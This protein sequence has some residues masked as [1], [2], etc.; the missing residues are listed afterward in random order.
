[1]LLSS[2]TKSIELQTNNAVSTDWYTAYVDI[3]PTTFVPG[4]NAGNVATATTT[5]IVAAPGSA[6]QRQVKLILV[7]NRSGTAN[8][9]VTVNLDVSATE[10]HL[11]PNVLLAPGEVLQYTPE[12]GWCVIDANGLPKRSIIQM[13]QL[14]SA[15]MSPIFATASLTGVKTITSGS[16]FAVY[17][18]KSPRSV[19]S[20]Q[21][22]CRVTT[23]MATITWGELAIAK[24]AIVIGGNP[25]LTVVGYAD[26]AALFNSTGQ[27]TV[28][29]NVSSGQII[30]PGDDLWVLIGNAATTAAIMRAQSI[31][32]DLQ[33]GFQAAL[34]TRP[35]L[36]VGAAQTYTLEAATTLATWV[37]M[38]I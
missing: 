1:M 16:T 9:N 11:S 17:V 38:I 7:R 34:V 29:V 26:V 30:N 5:E 4:D 14:S 27:K 8:Q 20:V 6:T 10:Y 13:G 35:S 25:S 36:N 24:G 2:S 28:S 32:D 19:S 18:G 15:F 22:R 37:A 33:V 21:V 23:A 3:T 31:A 12:G